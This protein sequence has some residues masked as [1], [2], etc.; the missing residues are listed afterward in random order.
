VLVDGVLAE[1]LER[2]AVVDGLGDGLD[3]EV[4]P[5]VAEGEALAAGG[6]EGE[7]ELVGVGAAELG[8]VIGDG[9]VVVVARGVEDLGDLVGERGEVG[10]DELAAAVSRARRAG[11][12][13][14][15]KSLRSSGASE[16]RRSSARAR[17]AMWGSVSRQP[18]A[19]MTRRIWLGLTPVSPG[20]AS[21]PKSHASRG[22]SRAC[23]AMVVCGFPF[24]SRAA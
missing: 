10:D 1:L 20:L 15:S 7:G 22:L 24:I 12:A 3:A 13:I 14:S 6:A 9:A 2:D 23:S 21:A 11:R 5:G 19:A 4:A 17:A 16:P 18:A 8:D